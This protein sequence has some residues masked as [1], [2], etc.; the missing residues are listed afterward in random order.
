[1]RPLKYNIPMT[2]THPTRDL[3]LTYLI[4]YIHMVVLQKWV[5][6]NHGLFQ[7]QLKCCHG[8]A[9][10]LR[11]NYVLKNVSQALQGLRCF[12]KSFA[13]KIIV[14]SDICPKCAAK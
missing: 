8:V 5:K 7:T 14:K 3:L 6:P 1:M 4:I 13:E 2:E 12:S 9:L 10:L 11:P